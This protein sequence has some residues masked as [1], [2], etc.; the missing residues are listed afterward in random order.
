MSALL[1]FGIIPIGMFENDVVY[2]QSNE[3]IIFKFLVNEVGLNTAAAC[4][5]LANIEKESGFEPDKKEYGYTWAE[6][7]GYGIC[8]WTNS[9]RTNPKG[10][11]EKMVNWCTQKGYDYKSLEGQLNYLKHE[12]NT[13]YYY[14][15]VTSKLLAVENSAQGAYDAGYYW[16]YYY[17][18]P[19][20]YKN[21]SKTRGN[22]AKNKYW[23]KYSAIDTN[24]VDIGTDFYAYIKNSSCGLLATADSVS[25]GG[26]VMMR[27][28]TGQKNQIWHFEISEDGSYVIT[29]A[30]D[31]LYCLDVAGAGSANGTNVDVREYKKS[32]AQQWYIYGSEGKYIL[33]AKCADTVL[34]T[35]VN[36]S[37]EDSNLQMWAKN[38]GET[39]LFSIE[40]LDSANPRYYLDVNGFLD[41]EETSSTEGFG[42][43]D[44]YINGRQAANDVTEFKQR[45][46]IGSSYEIKGIRPAAGKGYV[47]VF[48]GSI[49]GITDGEENVSLQF[50][51]IFN[52][53]T[54]GYLG[55]EYLTDMGN[56]V[57]FDVKINGVTVN[58]ASGD[59]VK[60][61]PYGTSYE[62]T[63]II[64][65]SEG[66]IIDT[67]RCRNLSGT[68][69]EDTQIIIALRPEDPVIRYDSN[70]GSGAPEDSVITMN[71]GSGIVTLSSDIPVRE[72]HKF[73]GWAT[74]ADNAE[75][76]YDAGSIFCADKTTTL[77]AQWEK[78]IIRDVILS[79][80]P[81]RTEYEFGEDLDP[82]GLELTVEYDDG[83][84]E[85]ITK[86]FIVSGFERDKEGEQIIIVNYD[87]YTFSFIINIL[88]KNEDESGV[89]P[90]DVNLDG[91]VS[92]SDATQILRHIN[93][94]TSVIDTMTDESI[95][96][97]ADVNASGD[98]SASDATQILRHINGK[99]SV[100]SE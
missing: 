62:I 44:V 20:N 60:E 71:T 51:T 2:A 41:G 1:V 28:E 56:H 68:L 52:L 40:K 83:T 84:K 16:C 38:G 85:V 18:V 64:S 47:G 73:M 75:H 74:E 66:Y 7:A 99:T 39:Q 48:K 97:K 22:S 25:D 87:E 80:L 9:P 43:F 78:L 81:E 96:A 6:G 21:V 94:K 19:G 10:R 13:S 5:V 57:M 11:R 82:E 77:Y 31:A 12:L 42:T 61:H 100:L 3:M 37:S 27:E 67:G 26:N 90:G 49:K 15:I 32:K 17:E 63:N 46:S 98:V 45:V 29:S 72:G 95:L 65:L 70:G 23:P 58:S 89:I 54:N 55:D 93:G 33:R 59:Y 14:R 79:A 24:G 86:S 50:G 76:L 91:D 8:Q 34:D 36:S 92:A 4:G 30:M 53:D 35:N 69:T 88:P